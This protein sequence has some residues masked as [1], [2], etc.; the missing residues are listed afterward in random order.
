ML[1]DALHAA[2]ENAEIAFHRVA[3]DLW[4]F[5]IDILTGTVVGSA[6]RREMLASM[7]KL[8]PSI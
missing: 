8:F 5:I 1:I 2:F 3:V 4:D 6:M 7:A